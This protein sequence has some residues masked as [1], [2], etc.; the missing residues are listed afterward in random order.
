MSPPLFFSLLL[1]TGG[2]FYF[3][4]WN[5][6][7]EIINHLPAAIFL[8][9]GMQ[10]SHNT[11]NVFNTHFVMQLLYCDKYVD[12]GM[13]GVICSEPEAGFHPSQTTEEVSWG[14]RGAQPPF[15]SG[16]K[17]DLPSTFPCS[18]NPRPERGHAANPSLAR[19]SV[20][21]IAL[22]APN[23]L[24][25]RTPSLQTCKWRLK[26]AKGIGQWHMAR[27][28]AQHH[29]VIQKVSCSRRLFHDSKMTAVYLYL[30]PQVSNSLFPS[31]CSAQHLTFLNN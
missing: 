9:S 8:H 5:L 2:Y 10:K 11:L 26:V 30:S 7:F 14:A 27:T 15:L 28:R 22:H 29:C 18:A 1:W 12:Q 13:L 23:N 19:C 3:I 6:Y 25:I 20:C 16:Q 17:Q 4:L 31:S 21:L 24:G